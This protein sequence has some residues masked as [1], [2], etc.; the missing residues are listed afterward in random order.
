[1]T[2]QIG[3]CLWKPSITPDEWNSAVFVQGKVAPWG[4]LGRMEQ[5][6]PKWRAY[7]IATCEDGSY[8]A[9]LGTPANLHSTG[10]DRS[11]SRVFLEKIIAGE[12]LDA[13]LLSLE[14]G[15]GLAWW[16]ASS[17]TLTLV[18]DPVGHVP[19]Y[20]TV[21]DAGAAWS[22]SA[23]SLGMLL[24]RFE[25]NP[26]AL[27]IY[28]E[29]RGVPAPYCLIDGIRKIQPGW[30][31]EIAPHKLDQRPFFLFTPPEVDPNALDI[32]SHQVHDLL[33]N[34]LQE[35]LAHTISPAGIF[36]SGGLDSSL[37]LAIASEMG[38]SLRA[39]TVGYKT[40]THTDESGLAAETAARFQAPCEV[41]KVGAAEIVQAAEQNAARLSEPVA[42]ITVFPELLLANLAREQVSWVLDG[43][44]A[45]GVFGGSDKY[46]A[47]YYV[48]L[49]L[50]I[51]PFLRH[52][53]LLPILNQLPSSRRWRLTNTVRKARILASGAE[54]SPVDRLIYWSIFF[55]EERIRQLLSPDLLPEPSR[56]GKRFLETLYPA[57]GKIS[58]A[59]K[60]AFT[61]QTSMP[62]IEIHKLQ[63]LE[64]LT[65]LTICNP[66][67]SPRVIRYGLG[68][69]DTYKVNRKTG[70]I[71]LRR[72]AQ[73]LLPESILRRKKANFSPP[74]TEW[75]NLE[76]GEAVRSTL[77]SSHALFEKEPVRMML[78]QN[79]S[80]AAD[81]R[82]EIWALYMLQV[83]WDKTRANAQE[84]YGIHS[85]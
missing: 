45:D 65:G 44:G 32:A 39:F 79:Q 25:I 16:N 37:L 4:L 46:I 33:K 83:W 9:V 74:I 57:T 30:I 55:H 80:G 54:L 72:L 56:P 20:Y 27:E 28:L 36:L 18:S 64:K 49:W 41:L 13:L 35:Q 1:M 12:N 17:Q 38:H 6:Y 24:S 71:V 53:L 2:P 67:L 66:F 78:N 11:I 58:L 61:L 42:D 26:T 75:L 70:K 76:L 34:I 59:Q 82:S 5:I 50:Q 8:L 69:P 47:D 19:L 68:L 60:S 52:G 51:P 23:Q 81:W 84:I 85:V 7:E 63:S 31:C 48:R 40:S 10:L 62:W 21:S 14:G 73:D 29:L 43:T 3:L 77:F 15:Y 22:T